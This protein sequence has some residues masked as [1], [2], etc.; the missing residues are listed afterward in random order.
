[1]RTKYFNNA[2][3]GIMSESTF[4]VMI[5]HLKLEMNVGAYR[6][7]NI[8]KEQV[9]DFYAMS[10]RLINAKSE[11][12]IAFIDSASRGWNLVMYGLHITKDDI[13]VTLES[14]YGTNLLTIY[15]IAKH[16]GCSVKIVKCNADGS[17]NIDEVDGALASGG[18]VL[19]VSHV[20]AQGSII[21]PVYE[22][23]RIAKKYGA[24]YIVDGCQAIGQMRV[25][26]Q[27]IGC[28]AYMAAGRKWLRGP[29]GTGIL[30]V[31]AGAP[32][33]TP[34][35]DLASAD[36]VFNSEKRV[37]G[38]KIRK[39]AKQFELWEKNI[40]SLLGLTN[41]IK[42]YLDYGIEKVSDELTIKANL[43]RESICGNSNLVLVGCKKASVGT[44]S[45]YMSNSGKEERVK[46][47]FESKGFIISCM[48]DW[49]CPLFFPESGVRYIFR[50][51]PHYYTSDEDIK[52]LCE[53]LQTL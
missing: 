26:V 33:Y 41:A 49:D 53:L 47:I 48:C 38:I 14:E 13:I 42:E 8:N 44:A 20:A 12:E 6:A 4:N 30:Y 50:L 35:I 46:E 43:I 25:D 21:N 45:F 31:R 11:E 37:L 18:T 51:T 2:G 22:F 10:A 16:T 7:A 23:G 52:E 9:A 39:D 27:K 5:E 28:H 36:I 24:T 1:M 32:I 40:A 15:D 17:C 19:A 29:R 34:Q 3:A